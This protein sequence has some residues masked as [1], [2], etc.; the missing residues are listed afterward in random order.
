MKAIKKKSR[1]HHRVHAKAKE[2]AST[3]FGIKAI[4][5]ISYI[6]AATFILAGAGLFIGGVILQQES[7][8]ANSFLQ[9]L[10]ASPNSQLSNISPIAKIA[11]SSVLNYSGPVLIALGLVFF[12][13]G[14]FRLFV[15]LNLLHG[16]AWSR[17]VVS[18]FSIT[19]IGFG[20]Y[21]I[22]RGNI[23]VNLV[24]II[25]NLVVLYYLIFSKEAH[26]F[27][28]HIPNN[29]MHDKQR[30]LETGIITF[31]DGSQQKLSHFL[32]K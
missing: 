32:K 13:I 18:C 31:E 4:S 9:V 30:K 20:F 5:L 19:W 28:H 8:I 1:L 26:N 14:L 6:A 15:G 11:I 12:F 16:K 2:I 17:V 21:S 22:S 7:E 25:F 27:F 29:H 24:T 3:P 23:W 10:I